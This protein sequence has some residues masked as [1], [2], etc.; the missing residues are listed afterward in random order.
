MEVLIRAI[1]Q[2]KIIKGIKVRRN[3]VVAVTYDMV[4]YVER[5]P[6]WLRQ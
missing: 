2:E 3:K 1:M 5:L 4:L 6:W